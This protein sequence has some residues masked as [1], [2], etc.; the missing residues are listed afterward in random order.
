VCRRGD[1]GSFRP[2]RHVHVDA[3]HDSHEHAN[4]DEHPDTDQHADLDDHTDANDD[5]HTE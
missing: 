4:P 3:N 2:L 1:A 5:A